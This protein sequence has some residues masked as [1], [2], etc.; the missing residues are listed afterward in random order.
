MSLPIE[1]YRFVP[2]ETATVPPGGLIEHFR[3]R[4]WLVHPE[5]GVAYY[6]GAR[7]K[8]ASPQCNG[9]EAVAR[10]LFTP[11]WAEIR[12]I[13]SVFRRIDPHDYCNR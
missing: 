13:P 2:I 7:G 3:D 8:D 6:V 9:D 5:R 1:H 12:F 10:R 11:D 4:W